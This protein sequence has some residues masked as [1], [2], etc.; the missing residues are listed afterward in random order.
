MW[1]R[2]GRADLEF[3]DYLTWARRTGARVA[4]NSSFSGGDAS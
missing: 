1:R 2:R 4:G 3:T